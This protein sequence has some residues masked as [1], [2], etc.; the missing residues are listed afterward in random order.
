MFSRARCEYTWKLLLCSLALVVWL[1]N[2]AWS[3]VRLGSVVP[4]PAGAMIRALA[5]DPINQNV[6]YAATDI[7][8]Y[9]SNDR[10]STWTSISLGL[11]MPP[12]A[13]AVARSEPNIVYAATPSPI[14]ASDSLIFKSVSGGAGWVQVATLGQAAIAALAVSP[15]NSNIVY[16]GAKF[17]IIKSVDAGV[18]WVRL[19]PLFGGGGFS[20]GGMGGGSATG[21]SVYIDDPVYHD[22]YIDDHIHIHIHDNRFHRFFDHHNDAKCGWNYLVESDATRFGTGDRSE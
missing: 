4:G 15:T 18:S 7:G 10:G 5:I 19:S 1:P 17:A 22:I 21:G 12:Q 3:A 11:P 2:N 14:S 6:I 20:S 16:A 9:R 8:A 13:L